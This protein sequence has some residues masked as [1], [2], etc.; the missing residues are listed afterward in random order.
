MGY[1]SSISIFACFGSITVQDYKDKE[2]SLE[3]LLFRP[4]T[5]GQTH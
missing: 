5:L 4:F 3:P 2:A 1:P